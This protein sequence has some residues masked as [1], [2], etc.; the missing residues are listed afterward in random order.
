MKIA[1]MGKKIDNNVITTELP[2]SIVDTTG[3]ANPP[4]VAVEDNLRSD[5]FPLIAAA[6]PPPA[7]IANAHVNTGFKSP[8]VATITTV[9][10]TAA[11]GTANVSKRLS[12]QGI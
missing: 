3:L 7:I 6:V 11:I 8:N 2:V 9:P 10:A 5:T 12:T 1:I 4:V